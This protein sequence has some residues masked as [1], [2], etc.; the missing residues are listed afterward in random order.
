MKYS[1]AI[2]L[3]FLAVT[4]FFDIKK[5]FSPNRNVLDVPTRV[6]VHFRPIHFV[7]RKGIHKQHCAIVDDCP[8]HPFLLWF[9]MHH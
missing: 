9:T 4:Q 1:A 6:T 8:K 3:R 5:L 2:A 7:P